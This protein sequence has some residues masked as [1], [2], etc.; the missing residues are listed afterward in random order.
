MSILASTD[1]PFTKNKILILQADEKASKALLSAN[2]KSANYYQPN[3]PEDPKENDLWFKTTL[4]G[5]TTN[6][7]QYVGGKW[8]ESFN[9]LSAISADLGNVVAGSITGVIINNGNGTFSVDKYGNLKAANAEI[10]GKIQA[11]GS[12]SFL[13]NIGEL[14]T[15]LNRV[16]LSEGNVRVYEKDTSLSVYHTNRGLTTSLAANGDSN[17]NTASS[18]LDLRSRDGATLHGGSGLKLRAKGYAGIDFTDVLQISHITLTS[19]GTTT[20]NYLF[21]DKNTFDIGCKNM[22]NVDGYQAYFNG[23]GTGNTLGASSD[24]NP[25]NQNNTP[26]LKAGGIRVRSTDTHFYV[27][28]DGAGG[29]LRVTNLAGNGEDPITYRPVRASQLDTTSSYTYKT[30][31]SEMKR[32]ANPILD[33]LKVCEYDLEADV[34]NGISN[35]QIG[36]ISEYSPQVAAPDGMAINIYKLLNLLLKGHQESLGDVKG[37]TVALEMALIELEEKEI[38]LK[39][40]EQKIINMTELLAGMETRLQALEK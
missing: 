32:L 11:D 20:N 6:F 24:T 40:A 5:I 34:Q 27:A 33:E 14:I 4:S 30:N 37:L 17:W 1:I 18:Y 7:Y 16:I 22:R 8:V 3:Q 10:I 2:G 23:T 28:V 12:Y 29:T 39:A 26:V 21:L 36:L 38:R 13:T 25:T 31:I 15:H 19:N 9:T 35:P